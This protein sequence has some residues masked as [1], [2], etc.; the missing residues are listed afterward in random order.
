M[1][2]RGE[3]KQIPWLWSGPALQ[4]G[5][6]KWLYLE[7]RGLERLL[8]WLFA[9]I[10]MY[11]FL[12]LFW[13]VKDTLSWNHKDSKQYHLLTCAGVLDGQLMVFADP[14]NVFRSIQFLNP[15]EHLLEQSL[16][17]PQQF[18]NKQVTIITNHTCWT[19]NAHHHH[20]FFLNYCVSTEGSASGQSQVF[21]HSFFIFCCFFFNQWNL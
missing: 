9:V 11:L 8:L 20:F 4:S 16:Q 19:H 3:S 2:Y 17:Q 13:L 1:Q 7:M 10:W 6:W 15:N 12:V 14:K 21:P 5:P 18:K